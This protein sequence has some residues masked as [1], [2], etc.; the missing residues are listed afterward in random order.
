MLA[1]SV[2][3]CV[4]E[5]RQKGLRGLRTYRWRRT[6]RFC[7]STGRSCAAP[8]PGTA[9]AP[10]CCPGAA[11]ARRRPSCAW[12]GIRVSSKKPVLEKSCSWEQRWY[13]GVRGCRPP[14]LLSARCMGRPR[15]PRPA[16][17]DPLR[18]HG[19]TS[20]N[21]STAG[22]TRSS[23]EEGWCR[24]VVQVL[25]DTCCPLYPKDIQHTWC[26]RRKPKARSLRRHVSRAPCWTQI[27]IRP[28][29]R[30]EIRA[31]GVCA[32][33]LVVKRAEM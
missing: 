19:G 29:I 24:I 16:R 8:C 20:R 31:R 32:L 9:G 10:R 17:E 22:L 21:Q 28:E 11:G 13:L 18:T 7:S 3:K 33:C 15:A 2:L 27:R 6:A 4:L 26:A 23:A 25:G 12:A 14:S 5:T 1:G 30:P